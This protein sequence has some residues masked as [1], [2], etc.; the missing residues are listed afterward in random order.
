MPLHRPSLTGA[1]L[2]AFLACLC[3]LSPLAFRDLFV[4]DEYRYA[5]V[6]REMLASGD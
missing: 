3:Y 6:A 5:E 4:P 1:Y 2:T